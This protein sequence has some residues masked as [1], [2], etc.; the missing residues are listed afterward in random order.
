MRRRCLLRRAC[1]FICLG[2]GMVGKRRADR[3][4]D[5]LQGVRGRVVIQYLLNHFSLFIYIFL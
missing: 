4:S 5:F 3:H 2:M 1:K